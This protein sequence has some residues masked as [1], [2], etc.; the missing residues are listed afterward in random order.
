VTGNHVGITIDA[1]AVWTMTATWVRAET[2]EWATNANG[3]TYGVMNE[4]GEP[5]LIAVITTD[6]KPG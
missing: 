3:N 6:N 5:D 4:H 2:T 1:N